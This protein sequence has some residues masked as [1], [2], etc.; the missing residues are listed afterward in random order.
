MRKGPV[1]AG[2]WSVQR[3]HTLEGVHSDQVNH[4]RHVRWQVDTDTRHGDAYSVSIGSMHRHEE[5]AG[6]PKV[7][8]PLHNLRHALV[9]SLKPVAALPLKG[10][11]GFLCQLRYRIKAKVVPLDVELHEFRRPPG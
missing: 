10:S 6:N 3:A 8:T 11:E 2:R 9:G 7:G 4:R 1:I 5:S